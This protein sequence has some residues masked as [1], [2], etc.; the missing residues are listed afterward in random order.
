M[1]ALPLRAIPVAIA[2][3]AAA[4]LSPV[5]AAALDSDLKGS[6]V[7]E[8]E[9]SHGFTVLGFAASERIDGRGDVGLIVYRKGA[10]VSYAAPATVTPTHLEADLGAL[11]SISAEIV[12][13]G[14]KKSLRSRCGDGG[15]RTF[16]PNLYRGTF[17]FHGEEGYADAVATE[18]PEF[19]RFLLDLGCLGSTGGE[20]SG[21]GLPGARLRAL[22]RHHGR[23]LSLQL[24]K[25]R[26]GKATVFSA[27]LAERRNGIRIERT[28]SGRQPARAFDYDPSLR[29]ATVALSTPFSGSASFDRDA[30][31]AGRWT[32]D[33]SVDFPGASDVPRA[34]AG[35]SAHLVHA[36]LVD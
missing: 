29:T 30:G 6:A 23:R 10:T 25:N 31:R 13:S 20:G 26:P 19:S 34:G 12:P 7:F 4:L 28:I 22:F 36:R 24:N 2:T 16:E 8:L 17:E 11:G 21:A 5:P 9:A 27:T 33:L 35:F 32:G 15:V 14:R 1:P 18:V 3:L